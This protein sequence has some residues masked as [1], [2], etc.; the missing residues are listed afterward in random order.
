MSARPVETV[1]VAAD[2]LRHNVQVAYPQTKITDFFKASPR[3]R[4]QELFTCPATGGSE[5]TDSKVSDTADPN[6]AIRPP[7]DAARFVGQSL[8]KV[9]AERVHRIWEDTRHHQP[10]SNRADGPGVSPLVYTSKEGQPPS[11]NPK[12]Q[13]QPATPLPHFA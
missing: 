13:A 1:A 9:N 12:P 5:D 8:R 4:P 2:P 6:L 7:T 3:G 10:G 11:L